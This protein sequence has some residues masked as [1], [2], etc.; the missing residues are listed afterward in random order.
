MPNVQQALA[1]VPHIGALEP[2][3]GCMLAL[4]LA[5]IA[6]PN[7]RYRDQIG[8]MA[9]DA[10]WHLDEKNAST[11][12]GCANY[13]ARLV[14]LSGPFASPSHNGHLAK[15]GN[16]LPPSEDSGPGEWFFTGHSKLTITPDAF[17]VFLLAFLTILVLASGVAK[18]AGLGFFSLP[19]LLSSSW[20]IWWTFYLLLG[21]MAVPL[22]FIYVG[23]RRIHWAAERVAYLKSHCEKQIKAS[24]LTGQIPN[25]PPEADELPPR[26]PKVVR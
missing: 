22:T 25:Y 24:K 9:R 5:Y 3:C 8:Q 13:Y 17:I 26:Q 10:L 14:K 15:D 1:V 7:F 20:N 11:I 18:E 4:C 6:L 21:A 12:D 2:I 16:G 19:E 23:R